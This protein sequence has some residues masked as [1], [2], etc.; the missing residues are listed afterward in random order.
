MTQ[1]Q[2]GYT[3]VDNPVEIETLLESLSQPGGA[4][5]QLED[6]QGKPL[7]VLVAEQHPGESLLLDISAIRE[8]AGEL[9]RGKAFRLMGQSRD[10]ML[11][12]PPLVMSECHDRDGRLLCHSAYPLALEVLQRRES[13]RARLRL[14]ME[15][16]VIVRANGADLHLQGDLKDLSLEGCQ[17]ELPITS[18]SQL[19]SPMPLELELCFPNG[20][21]AVVL[22]TPRHHVVDTERQTIKV[23]FQFVTLSGDQ[24]R[25]L[26]VFVREIERES[27]R[28]ASDAD[29]T[30][31]PSPLFQYPVTLSPSVGRRYV[32]A[33]A[34]PMARRMARV[35]GYLDGQLLELQRG[36]DFDSVQLSR[37]A[38]RLLTLHDEDRE[39]TLF[40]TR[41]MLR[42]PL[43]VRRGLA[44]AVHLLD[45]S[46]TASMPRDVRKAVVA[47]GMVHDLGE[48]LLPEEVMASASMDAPRR[49]KLAS[50]VELLLPRLASCQ[51]LS[52]SVVQ[53]LVERINERLDGSGYPLGL[54]G[55]SLGEL[56]RLAMVV[57]TVDAMRRDCQDRPAWRVAEIYRH[58]LGHPEQFDQRWVKRYITHFGLVPI[59]SL[60]RFEGGE[61][62]WVQ[63]LDD[64]GAPAQVQRCESIKPP[65]DSLG[66]VVRD[67]RLARLGRIVEEIP[68]ST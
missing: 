31:Q 36:S 42:E 25:Q 38:D 2:D 48:S 64:K 50:H 59:G 43:P 16:G 66:Q 21:R 3:R 15:V 54:T 32:Q 11:R 67:E 44:V 27:T 13:F 62:G 24:E 18:A 22:G 51:W 1:P 60:V 6:D 47:C 17:V 65:D 34:T 29:A 49:G 55:E 5:L 28:Q 57:D 68:L 58:L 20:A 10:K 7:P 53:S 35:A 9:K 4:S 8:V 12:S 26:W 61:L 45:I 41:C 33:H 23:G 37:H 39:A 46:A 19:A 52:S 14:G 30:L 63:R 40:A 56:T